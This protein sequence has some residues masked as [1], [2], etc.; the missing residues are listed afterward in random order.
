[1]KISDYVNRRTILFLSLSILALYM[2]YVPLRDLFNSSIRSDFYDHIM[3]IPLLSA[4]LLYTKRKEIFSSVEYGFKAGIPM[5]AL[6]FLLFFLGKRIAPE[7][8][9]NDYSS[10]IACSTIFIFIGSFVCCY[11][12]RAFKSA[13]FPLLFLVFMIPVPT[14]IMDPFIYILTLGSAEVTEWLFRLTG[15]TYLREGVVFHL[16]GVSIEVAREC[17]GIRST[18]ALI[19]V[20]VLASYMFL[21]SNWT[22]FVLVLALFPL[23]ILKNGI[24][25]VTIT[26]LAVY[27]D[28]SFLTHGFLHKSGGVFFFIP[29]LALL[30]LILYFLRKGEKTISS[31]SRE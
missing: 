4:Y 18:M 2:L 16:S 17:S 31:L 13:A 9:Q 19:V 1:M 24:R 29:S 10:L 20:V 12:V 22:R 11:G 25:I 3:V 23:T 30:G 8:N 21:R 27:V 14:F 28:K 7:L 6:G 15:T 26:L 5:M